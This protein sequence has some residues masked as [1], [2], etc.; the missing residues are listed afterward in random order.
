[1]TN[2]RAS[3]YKSEFGWT[4]NRAYLRLGDKIV[5]PTCRFEIVNDWRVC[6]TCNRKVE[7]VR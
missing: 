1:M 2:K 7:K 5:K 4:R 3:R 6:V